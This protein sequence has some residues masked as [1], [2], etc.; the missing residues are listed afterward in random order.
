MTKQEVIDFFSHDRFAALTEIEVLEV[1]EGYAQTRII[2]KDK[3]LN[4]NNVVMGGALFTMADFTFSL[5]ANVGSPCVT[6]NS[7][8]SFNSPATGKELIATTEKLKEGKTVS[9]Y[10]VRIEDENGRLIA[11]ATFTGYKTCS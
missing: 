6:L 5:A 3:H 1:R 8:I 2:V 7:S 10:L 4:G 11:N 9:N